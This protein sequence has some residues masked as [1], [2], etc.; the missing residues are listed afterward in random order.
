MHL[1]GMTPEVYR[2]DTSHGFVEYIG[3]YEGGGRAEILF[4]QIA[5]NRYFKRNCAHES[6]PTANVFRP[7]D[8]AG[9]E[10]Q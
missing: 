10:S 7:G 8:A 9:F 6:R 2:R 1:A 5:P 4:E 3:Y